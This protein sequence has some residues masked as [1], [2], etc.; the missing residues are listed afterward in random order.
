MILL[1]FIMSG[2]LL[3]KNAWPLN[4][5]TYSTSAINRKAIASKWHQDGSTRVRSECCRAGPGRRQVGGHP[6]SI[7]LF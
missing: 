3:G 1:N 6:V 2:N 7:S 5:M 4:Q